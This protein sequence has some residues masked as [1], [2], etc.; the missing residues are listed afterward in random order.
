MSLSATRSQYA[1]GPG[2]IVLEAARPSPFS[3]RTELAFTLPRAG[4]A[5]LSVYD[6][7]GRHVRAVPVVRTPRGRTS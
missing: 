1:P 5:T 4:R 6:V 2:S 3:D 7:S